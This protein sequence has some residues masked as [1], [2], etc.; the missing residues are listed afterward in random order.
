MDVIGKYPDDL[1]QR[2]LGEDSTLSVLAH[3]VGHRWLANARFRDGATISTELLGRDEVHW[4]FFADTDGSFLEGNDIAAA[5]GRPLPHRRGGAALQRAGPVPDGHARRERGGAA[6]LRA[7]PDRHRHRSRPRS[8]RPA[9]PSA[10]TRTD[11]TIADIVAAIGDRNPRGD[12]LGAALPPGVR[13]RHGG[14]ARGPR[15]HREGGAHPRRLAR[16]LRAG[17][18]GPR[19]RRPHAELSRPSSPRSGRDETAAAIRSGSVARPRRPRAARRPAGR[20]V[21]RAG[22]RAAAAGRGPHLGARRLARGQRGPAPVVGPRRPWSADRRFVV[23]AHGL[24][25]RAT[26]SRVRCAV[27]SRRLARAAAR[28]GRR[29]RG[30]DGHAAGD[31]AVADLP[32]PAAATST[33]SSPPTP[34]RRGRARASWSTPSSVRFDSSPRPLRRRAAPAAAPRRGRLRPPLVRAG[35]DA[36][37]LGMVDPRRAAHRRRRWRRP[38]EPVAPAC[39]SIPP[40]AT[41]L[42]IAALVVPVGPRPGRA[43][44][45]TL[46]ARWSIAGTVAPRLRADRRLRPPLRRLPVGAS[47][48]AARAGRAPS[49]GPEDPLGRTTGTYRP[50]GGPHARPGPRA[51]GRAARR[52]RTS[53]TCSSSPW[54]GSWPPRPGPPPGPDPARGAGARADVGGPSPVRRQRGLGQP[55]HGHAGRDLL[56]GQRSWCSSSPALRPRAGHRHGGAGRARP[57]LEGDR[58]HAAAGGLARRPRGAAGRGPA[59]GGASSCACSCSWSWPTSRCGPASSPRRCCA[60]ETQRGAWLRLRRARSPA[61]GCASC[62]CSTRRSSGP[63]GYEHWFADGAAGLAARASRARPGRRALSSSGWRGVPGPSDERSRRLAGPGL[64]ARRDRPDPRRTPGPLSARAAPGARVRDRRRRDGHGPG[65][66]R[67]D[68]ARLDALPLGR[69]RPP[70]SVAVGLLPSVAVTLLAVLL[71]PVSFDTIRAWRPDGFFA[72]R[73]IEWSRRHEDWQ[74]EL[75][76]E[77]RALFLAQVERQEH[78]RRL[79]GGGGPP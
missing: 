43:A 29:A 20:R 17:G 68:W 44:V 63:P 13:V 40:P 5:G 25:A 32:H 79:L 74:A 16:L 77:S 21:R 57:G 31:A 11:V 48:D 22:Q 54:P 2:F 7:Q 30:L 38:C 50:T 6:L 15:R 18:R 28:L 36:T 47:V 78:A 70:P 8:R 37:A 42:R 56:P 9:S 24:P 34:T 53:R 75:T 76:P 35:G 14:R 58:G 39:G 33:S 61:T 55:A 49:P 73:A 19:Q 64:A 66:P 62:P 12:A 45:R 41:T 1:N 67:P 27:E 23:H 60:G 71:L 26:T 51:L 46:A 59:T 72:A 10:G 4:S 69:G 52:A 3:E 65:T